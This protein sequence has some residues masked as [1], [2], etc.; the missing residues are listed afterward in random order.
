MSI[1]NFYKINKEKGISVYLSVVIMAIILSI[2]LGL[3]VILIGQIKTMK[4][5]QNSVIAFYGA[6][7]GIEQMLVEQSAYIAPTSMNLGTGGQVTYEVW[8]EAG[9]DV[10]ETDPNDWC[11]DSSSYCVKSVGTYNGTKRAIVIT[12]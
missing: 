9:I 11:P 12:M 4:N 1:K 2:I 8:G 5:V 10:R 7:T 6:D 3:T